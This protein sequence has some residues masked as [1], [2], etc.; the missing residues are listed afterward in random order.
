MQATADLPRLTLSGISQVSMRARDLDRAIEFYHHT[1]GLELLSR[2]E[3]MAFVLAGSVRIMLA[4]P[5][6]PEFD[7][8]GSILYFD[9]TDIDSEFAALQALGVDV[10]REPFVAHREDEHEFWLAFF[11]DSEGNTLGL[12]Q[13]RRGPR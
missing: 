1:L 11:R 3:G 13:W 6:A 7:H 5:S 2:H 8:P 9:C 10:L 4:V 12:T